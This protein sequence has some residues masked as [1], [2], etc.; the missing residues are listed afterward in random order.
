VEEA[1]EDSQGV[2]A[3]HLNAAGVLQL[4]VGGSIFQGLR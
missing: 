4:R 2:V 3:A 1:P